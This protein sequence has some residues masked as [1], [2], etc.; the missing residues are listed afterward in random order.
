MY[1]SDPI[2]LLLKNKLRKENRSTTAPALQSSQHTSMFLRLHSTQMPC[3]FVMMRGS[4]ATALSLLHVLTSSSCW[5]CPRQMILSPNKT[6][7]INEMT[8]SLRG[9]QMTFERE[10]RR[11][12]AKC[13]HSP[14]KHFS[15]MCW[16]LEHIYVELQ[17]R[18]TVTTIVMF[19]SNTVT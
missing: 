4:G 7:P 15:R 14:S 3:H 17:L 10:A 13:L 2:V 8:G 18:K 9:P 6:M 11:H 16:I 12:E 19:A 1:P 5:N